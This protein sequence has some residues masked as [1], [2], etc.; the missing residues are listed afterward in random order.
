MLSCTSGKNCVA[1][2]RI[3]ACNVSC[4]EGNFTVAGVSLLLK[5]D[6]ARATRPSQCPEARAWFTMRAHAAASAVSLQGVA[7]PPTQ[8]VSSE[9]NI[10]TKSVSSKFTSAYADDGKLGNDQPSVAVCRPVATAPLGA[11]P[12][13]PEEAP[14]PP[15]P[16]PPPQAENTR[17]ASVNM[18]IRIR[19]RLLTAP[20]IVL[21]A[22]VYL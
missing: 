19:M 12:P 3:I 21:I 8:M 1:N 14:P 5:R 7:T 22:N 6:D 20:P 17:A 16:A 9:P 15:P 11:S 13:P 4:C 18:A 10:D 2:V